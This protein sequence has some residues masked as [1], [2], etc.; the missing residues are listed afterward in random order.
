[1]NASRK[2]AFSTVSNML[3][4]VNPA[5]TPFTSLVDRG[6]SLMGIDLDSKFGVGAN[7]GYMS[8]TSPTDLGGGDSDNVSAP[9]AV[10]PPSN[11]IKPIDKPDTAPTD[12]VRRRRRAGED[13]YGVSSSNPFLNFSDDI[14]TSGM[15]SFTGSARSG[16]FKSAPTGR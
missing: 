16:Q 13:V 15:G 6:A 14:D 3:G 10:A 1:M 4:M 8:Q 2:G 9:P 11:Q 5:L 12:L 7:D